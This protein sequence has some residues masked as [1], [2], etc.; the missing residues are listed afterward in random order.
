MLDPTVVGVV[1]LRRARAAVVLGVVFM[2]AGCGSERERGPKLTGRLLVDGQPCRPVS[3]N[4]FDLKF[5][6]VGGEGPFKRSYVAEV[7]PDG[8][9]MVNGSIGQGIPVGRYKISIVGKVLDTQGKPTGRFVP[10]FTDKASP[11]EV[12]ISDKI[13]EIVIDLEKK[14]VTTS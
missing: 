14:K 1:T 8:E 12:E 2:A 11:L 6:S 3:V 9:F 5:T 13:S 4:D 10:M 7:E